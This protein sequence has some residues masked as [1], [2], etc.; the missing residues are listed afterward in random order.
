MNKLNQYFSYNQQILRL[1][2]NGCQPI[3]SIGG[4]LIRI[5]RKI[6]CYGSIGKLIT[7]VGIQNKEK[8]MLMMDNKRRNYNR[9]KQ[10]KQKRFTN[11]K[12]L[13]YMKKNVGTLEQR[14]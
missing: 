7:I 6:D 3:T 10:Q 11:L 9:C 2:I 12:K 8:R 13:Q 1:T 14:N 5:N 4:H